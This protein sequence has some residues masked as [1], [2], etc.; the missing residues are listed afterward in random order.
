[1]QMAGKYCLECSKS[2]GDFQAN[3][4]DIVISFYQ[5]EWLTLGIMNNSNATVNMG[6]VE[7]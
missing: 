2:L 7:A 5:L 3:E 4:N 1:M 6:E